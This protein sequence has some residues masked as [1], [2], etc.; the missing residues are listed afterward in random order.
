[1]Y[2]NRKISRPKFILIV[3]LIMS[4]PQ[5]NDSNSKMPSPMLSN[6]TSMLGDINI[7]T[8]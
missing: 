6:D 3:Q 5:P 7:G 2:S 4:S 8:N 1:M